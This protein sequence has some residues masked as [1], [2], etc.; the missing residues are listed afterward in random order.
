MPSDLTFY[1]WAPVDGIRTSGSALRELTLDGS[2]AT[3]DKKGLVGGS[4]PPLLN[5][6][7]WEP[8]A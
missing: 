8:T 6:A 7:D 3:G 4:C 5:R 1:G 2:V